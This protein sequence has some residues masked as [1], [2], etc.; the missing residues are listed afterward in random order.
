MMMDQHHQRS[1]AIRLNIKVRPSFHLRCRPDPH[2]PG[3]HHYRRQGQ[4]YLV[5]Y[6]Q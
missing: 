2:R 4:A 1:P 5:S 3:F 6:L